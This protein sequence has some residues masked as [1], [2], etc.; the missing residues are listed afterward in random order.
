MRRLPE[1]VDDFLPAETLARPGL[2]SATDVACLG[3]GDIFIVLSS[4]VAASVD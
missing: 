2:P 4:V 1:E 3:R